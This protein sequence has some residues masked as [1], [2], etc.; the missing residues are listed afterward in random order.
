M[1]FTRKKIL[2]ATT[3]IVFITLLIIFLIYKIWSISQENKQQSLE[4]TQLLD[5]SQTYSNGW[6]GYSF[7]YPKVAKIT[8][9]G[10]SST[11]NVDAYFLDSD[12]SIS[13]RTDTIS[14]NDSCE[15]EKLDE[16]RTVANGVGA[17]KPTDIHQKIRDINKDGNVWE[18][19][20]TDYYSSYKNPHERFVTRLTKINNYYILFTSFPP[21]GDEQY[22]KIFSPMCES[23]FLTFKFQINS[24]VESA[25]EA[26]KAK[27]E[28]INFA[29]K[30]LPDYSFKFGAFYF[31]DPK[32]DQR[33]KEEFNNPL[34]WNKS[35]IAIFNKKEVGNIEKLKVVE[36]DRVDAKWTATDNLSPFIKTW[37]ETPL[38]D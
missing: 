20:Y 9:V 7:N 22:S 14:E 2:L 11:Q 28:A 12:V 33:I 35:A 8:A 36:L 37:V 21:N 30:K 1:I 4:K 13:T 29:A 24:A 31:R 25:V 5:H 6:Y 32:T 34:L 16:P 26:S 3:V 17:L 18:E 23:I 10:D 38:I 27:E 19:Y 15:L